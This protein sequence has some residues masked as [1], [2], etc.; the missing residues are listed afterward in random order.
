MTPVKVAAS[1]PMTS[2]SRTAQRSS[3]VLFR[4]CTTNWYWLFEARPPRRRFCT[5]VMNTER[6][7]TWESW[8]RRS[9]S[10]FG[11]SPRWP[12]GFSSTKNEPAFIVP[13]NPVEPTR[14]TTC[15]TCGERSRICRASRCRFTI[16]GKD[17]SWRASVETESWPMSSVG[18]KPFGI[19]ANMVTVATTEARKIRNTVKRKR[20]ERSRSTR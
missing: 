6:P 7:G 1:R 3:S 19:A 4:P 10:T 12:F 15:A 8:R 11:S 18:K 20:S 17:T 5:G 9:A 13:E 16:A 2:D 14:L